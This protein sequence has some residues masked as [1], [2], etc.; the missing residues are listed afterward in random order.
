MVQNRAAVHI[1]RLRLHWS[2]KVT[3]A[4]LLLNVLRNKRHRMHKHSQPPT[5]MQAYLVGCL[6]EMELLILEIL[7]SVHSPPPC[8]HVVSRGSVVEIS[9]SQKQLMTRIIFKWQ[10][11]PIGKGEFG[12]TWIAV[13]FSDEQNWV[14]VIRRKNDVWNYFLINIPS[15][16]NIVGDAGHKRGPLFPFTVSFGEQPNLYLY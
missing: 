13:Q 12:K 9:R 3:E 8:F 7:Y 15:F 1:N 6:S 14:S 11:E 10:R 5:L 16:E 4:L 2:L